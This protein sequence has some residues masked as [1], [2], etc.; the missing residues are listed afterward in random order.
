MLLHIVTTNEPSYYCMV[1]LGYSPHRAHKD[2]HCRF[3][4]VYDMIGSHE[5]ESQK[6][7]AGDYKSYT[8]WRN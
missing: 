5:Q 8:R 7:Y 2:S 1:S 6:Q 3:A 4:H